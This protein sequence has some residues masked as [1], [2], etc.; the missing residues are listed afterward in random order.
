L[1]AS[2]KREEIVERKA[3]VWLWLKLAAS[4]KREEIV[5]RKGEVSLWL[6]LAGLR[7]R[8]VW[9]LEGGSNWEGGNIWKGE[10]LLNKSVE[11][12]NGETPGGGAMIFV[13]S[14]TR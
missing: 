3:E 14:N 7:K 5:E 9:S 6:K 2:R 8:E 4:R 13:R 11:S 10:I 1:A 12:I